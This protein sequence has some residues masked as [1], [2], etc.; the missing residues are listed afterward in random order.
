MR[1]S[2]LGQRI[3]FTKPSVSLFDSVFQIVGMYYNSTNSLMEV[4][5]LIKLNLITI[6]FV[7]FNEIENMP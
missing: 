7:F 2:I 6:I 3:M 1:H 4:Q 5:L